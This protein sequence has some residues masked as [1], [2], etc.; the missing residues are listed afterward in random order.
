MEKRTV[1]IDCDPGIDDSLALMLALVS[2]EIRIAGITVVSGNVPAD[3]GGKNAL[4]ILKFMGQ[5][6]IPVC[7]GAMV[8]LKREYISAKDTHGEDGLG[9][10]G[11]PE[12]TEASVHPGAVDFILD[13]LKREEKVSIIAIGPLTN[14]ALAL[15][16]EP[17]A[18][19]NLDMLVSMG[20]CFKSYGNCSPVAEY[21][22]WCDPDSA[23]YVYQNLGRKIH[24]V[25]LDVTREIVL[26]PNILEYMKR[27]DQKECQKRGAF[28]EAITRF[29]FDYHWKYENLIGCVVNDPLAVAYFLNPQLLSGF[30]AYVAVETGGISIGQ[31]VVDAMGFWKRQ[32]NAHVLTQVDSLGFWSFFLSR[33][34]GMEE[35]RIRQVLKDLMI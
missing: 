8:P 35:E 7:Q 28:V 6:D 11:I 33:L 3:Q 34:Y 1:I 23:E 30:D 10:S 4:K 16:K 12:I 17:L 29:Y 13:T 15:K 19:Q 32:P 21:N 14:L 26:S 2:P 20:G 9:E 27:L 18:F 5:L 24:M 31:S 25:G 22:Y